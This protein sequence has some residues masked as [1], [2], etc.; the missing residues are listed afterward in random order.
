MR[1]R[2][3]GAAA[4]DSD[5]DS[6]TIAAAPPPPAT[7]RVARE[8]RVSQRWAQAQRELLDPAAAARAYLE[9]ACVPRPR[10]PEPHWAPREAADVRVPGS[11]LDFHGAP[12]ARPPFGGYQGSSGQA[13]R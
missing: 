13:W 8:S 1:W 9:R 3:L 7:A 12:G 6:I 11:L 5:S 4:P 10:A 2:R